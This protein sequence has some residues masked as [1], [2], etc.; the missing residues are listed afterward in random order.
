MAAV[1]GFVALVLTAGIA[2][3]T[4][5]PLSNSK[6]WWVRMWDFPRLQIAAATLPAAALALADPWSPAG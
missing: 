6:R 4:L 1:A 3:V 2:A 5:L